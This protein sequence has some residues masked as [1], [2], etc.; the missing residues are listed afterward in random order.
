M[1]IGVVVIVGVGVMIGAVT[2]GVD[3]IV[4]IIGAATV[5][6]GGTYFLFLICILSSVICARIETTFCL[7]S[8]IVRL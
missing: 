8:V 1:L 5:S 4:F 3:I 7:Y 2:V 6:T